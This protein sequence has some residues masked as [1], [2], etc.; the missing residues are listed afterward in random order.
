MKTNELKITKHQGT[1][2]LILA[3]VFWLFA[4]TSP[5][6]SHAKIFGDINGDQYVDL[7]DAVQG[8]NLMVDNIQT[9]FHIDAD[10]NGD[11]RI[12]VEEILYTLY[13]ASGQ[14][15]ELADLS[16]SASGN[17]SHDPGDGKLVLDIKQSDFPETM[18]LPI[19]VS[20]LNMS[21]IDSAT[22]VVEFPPEIT[23]TQTDG[24]PGDIVG[25]WK[26]LESRGCDELE[27]AFMED[28]SLSIQHHSLGGLN[29]VG[30]DFHSSPQTSNPRLEVSREPEEV[31]Q[32]SID[33]SGPDGVYDGI[34]LQYDSQ[35][36]GWEKDPFSLPVYPTG[37]LWWISKTEI[38]YVDGSRAVYASDTPFN[39]YQF[40]THAPFGV[41][42][43]EGVHHDRFPAQDY[44]T[45]QGDE[46]FYI[47]TFPNGS[48]KDN[49]TDPIMRI[50]RED[51][52][53]HWI[54]YN[55]DGGRSHLASGIKM[56]MNSGE[57]YYICVEDYYANGG[58]YSIKVSAVGFD[59]ASIG[60]AAI[61]DKFEPDDDPDQAGV[62]SL[63]DVQDHSLSVGDQ[64]WFRFAAP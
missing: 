35:D 50:Y 36:M 12:G 38:I 64:D 55:D 30:F 10:V 18:G 25:S 14:R 52:L 46:Y 45:K 58:F 51:D 48:T 3:V 43:T 60:T 28:G 4:A 26:M 9:K 7:K 27:M 37:G 54:A 56:P 17:Y 5:I 63:N 16:F 44:A 1:G 20:T 8:L 24:A 2:H 29:F 41:V 34:E 59:G 40:T 22:I 15:S 62:L 39:A 49:R 31:H 11:G 42:R 19:G 61:P 47:E 23:L 33:L 57:I 6:S 21:R 13:T 32:I 53:V